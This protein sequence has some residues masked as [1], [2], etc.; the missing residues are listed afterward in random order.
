MDIRSAWDFNDLPATRSRLTDL[1]AAAEG[2]A[3]ACVLTQLARVDGLEKDFAAASAKLDRARALVP[4]AA[5]EAGA[6]IAL[7]AGRLARDQG[8]PAAAADLFRTARNGAQAA[9]LPGLALDALHM[10]AILA[11]ADE[12][13]TLAAEAEA[14]VEAAG[15]DYRP[16]LGPILNNLGWTLFEDGRHDDA[17]GCFG[18]D[19]ALRAELGRTDQR[20][21]ADWNLG[22]VLRNAGKVD[23]AFNVQRTLAAELEPDGPRIAFVYSELAELHAMC[24]RVAEAG[25]LARKSLAAHAAAGT[26]NNMLAERR[27]HM[28]R[29]AGQTPQE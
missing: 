12:A 26:L 1:L 16:W 4:T 7:E 10:L 15:A 21:I 5:G 2:A 25:D 6:R 11:P 3:A 19:S 14:L 27:A 22:Y 28:E 8:D 18:R 9:G 24:G 17:A 23:V 13:V 20:R 29:L